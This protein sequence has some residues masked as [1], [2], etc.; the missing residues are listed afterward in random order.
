M[1]DDAIKKRILEVI[2]DIGGNSSELARR[3]GVSPNHLAS[4]LSSESKGISATIFKGFS[5]AGISLDWLVVGK[6]AMWINGNDTLES[7]KIRAEEA[8]VEL[9]SVQDSVVKLEYYIEQLERLN[10]N[11]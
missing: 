3:I 4:I 11:Q 1:K 10:R 8:Q 2:E 6:N 7:W 9:D 5:D